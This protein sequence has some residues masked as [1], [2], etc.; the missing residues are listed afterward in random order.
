M[1]AGFTPDDEARMREL[2]TRCES[3]LAS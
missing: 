3:S 2:L 1:T